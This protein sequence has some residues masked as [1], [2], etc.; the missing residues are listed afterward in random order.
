MARSRD[1][2]AVA[3]GTRAPLRRPSQSELSTA[4]STLACSPVEED[5]FRAGERLSEVDDFSDLDD[6]LRPATLWRAIVGWLR[7]ERTQHPE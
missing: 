3:H 4:L 1:S 5:F 6:G 2:G 7:G